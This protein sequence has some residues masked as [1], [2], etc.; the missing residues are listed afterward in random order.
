MGSSGGAPNL[1]QMLIAGQ[2]EEAKKDVQAA[3]QAVD[4]LDTSNDMMMD[5]VPFEE[6]EES[7]PKQ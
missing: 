1:Q 5:K 3:M 6:I 7:P 2:Q 4:E